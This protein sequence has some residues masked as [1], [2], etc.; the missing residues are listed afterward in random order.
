MWCLGTWFS[1]GLG[2]V[3]LRVGLDDHAFSNLNDSMILFCD[4]FHV[5]IHTHIYEIYDM[6]CVY[7]CPQRKCIALL[8]SL[9]PKETTISDT[10]N[11]SNCFYASGQCNCYLYLTEQGW[12]EIGI[13]CKKLFGDTD[14]PH[15]MQINCI[16]VVPRHAWNFLITLSISCIKIVY[17]YLSVLAFLS[18]SLFPLA[19]F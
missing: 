4:W 2:S 19:S 11:W 1:S 7:I 14:T 16:F 5:C 15:E 3:T 10:E 13:F 18:L 9:A 17:G 8:A 6:M 12:Q